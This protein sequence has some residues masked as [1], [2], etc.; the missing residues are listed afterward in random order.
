MAQGPPFLILRQAI[1]V[2]VALASR[3]APGEAG[4]RSLPGALQ[5]MILGDEVQLAVAQRPP[6]LLPQVH[7]SFLSRARPREFTGLRPLTP[8]WTKL[9]D[10]IQLAVAQGLPSFIWTLLAS[11]GRRVGFKGHS[12]A[13]RLG[14]LHQEV[15]L[16]MAVVCGQ[17]LILWG[18]TANLG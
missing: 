18:P 9:C 1:A 2:A 17:P 3:R 7:S 14:E 8:E 10:E 13:P 15:Q 5:L 12:G 6:L 11:P 16:A 4:L